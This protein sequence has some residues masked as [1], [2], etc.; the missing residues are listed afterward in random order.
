MDFELDTGERIASARVAITRALQD[1]LSDG[2]SWKLVIEN[3]Q[4]ASQAIWTE[5]HALTHA[6]EA[7]QGFGALILTGPTELAR[8]L[9]ARPLS[10]V[11]SRIVVMF[12]SCRWI[13]T[14][15]AS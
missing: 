12:I 10:A 6:M 14:R 2:R 1:D 11:A 3:A 7:G 4:N 15:P 9:A 8:R 13:S 5:V